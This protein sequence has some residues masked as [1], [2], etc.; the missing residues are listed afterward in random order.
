V[1]T[2]CRQCLCFD[3]SFLSELHVV[4]MRLCYV[5]G[6]GV[7]WAQ[8]VRSLVEHETVIKTDEKK[9]GLSLILML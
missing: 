5:T 3:I 8:T 6:E 7:G 1:L 4:C 2:I 9:T